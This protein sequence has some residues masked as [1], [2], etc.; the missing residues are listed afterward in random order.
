MEQIDRLYVYRLYNIRLV[1]LSKILIS[2]ENRIKSIP[3]YP[4]GGRILSGEQKSNSKMLLT[5]A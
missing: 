3:K 2:F 4:K 5:M 1:G